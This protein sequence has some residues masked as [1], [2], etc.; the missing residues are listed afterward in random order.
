M[1]NRRGAGGGINAVH[2]AITLEGMIAERVAQEATRIA[3][4]R[5]RGIVWPSDLD[6]DR[7]AERE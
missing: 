5:L 4:E 3:E 2:K 1:G 7:V 6:P